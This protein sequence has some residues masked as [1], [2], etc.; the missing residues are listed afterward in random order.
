MYNICKCC[1]F[2]NPENRDNKYNSG[3]CWYPRMPYDQ[4]FL[5]R[6]EIR[7]LSMTWK[8]FV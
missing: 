2:D 6:Y 3:C 1:L 8:W 4:F 5:A 7:M